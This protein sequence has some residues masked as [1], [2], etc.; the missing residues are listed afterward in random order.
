MK[1][2]T[3][4]IGVA[5]GLMA[6]GGAW[7]AGH[8]GGE[9]AHGG[10]AAPHPIVSGPPASHGGGSTIGSGGGSFAGGVP[11]IP[12]TSVMSNADLSAEGPVTGTVRM[13]I[14]S[15]ASAGGNGSGPAITPPASSDTTPMGPRIRALRP[16]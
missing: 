3:L 13:S 16:Y 1:T 14:M 5:A 12:P 15:G 10:G 11:F 4:F 9:R 7:A 6:A 8:M 2:H